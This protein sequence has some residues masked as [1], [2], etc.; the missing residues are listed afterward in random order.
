MFKPL[1]LAALMAVALPATA[2]DHSRTERVQFARGASSATLHGNIHGYDTVDYV[3]AARGGQTLNVR[4]QPTN[5]S[6]YFN[7]TKQGA[8]EALFVGSTSGDR[9]SGRLPSSG[10]YVVRVYLMRNAARRDEHANYSLTI[11]V[12]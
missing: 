6:A 12:R 2:Q 5:A 4:L 10:D 8:D 3:L 1:L 11:G 9:F 7:V